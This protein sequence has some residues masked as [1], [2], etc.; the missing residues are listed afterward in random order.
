VD[1]CPE[2]G[3]KITT[4]QTTNTNMKDAGMK[5]HEG[6]ES[7]ICTYLVQPDPR[8]LPRLVSALGSTPT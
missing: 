4:Q 3:P 5:E 8:A 1:F 6:T 2:S 7:Q